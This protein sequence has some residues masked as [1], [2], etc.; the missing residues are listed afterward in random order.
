LEAVAKA[1]G[2]GIGVLLTE[3]GVIGGA[4]TR[5]EVESRLAVATLEVPEPY[6]AAVAA[7]ELPRNISVQ[8]FPS[9][10]DELDVFLSRRTGK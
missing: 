8:T 2:S 9:R 10:A 4:S 5:S 7:A 1:R 3:T 6:V